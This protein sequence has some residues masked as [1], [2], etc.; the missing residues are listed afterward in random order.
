MDGHSKR[1]VLEIFNMNLKNFIAL[2]LFLRT[3]LARTTWT[4]SS[5]GK[6]DQQ[7]KR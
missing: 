7:L 3:I 2:F 5:E 6:Q 1:G 4:N